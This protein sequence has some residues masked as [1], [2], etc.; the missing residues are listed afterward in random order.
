M[1]CR[2]RWVVLSALAITMACERGAPP[3][4]VQADAK[5]ANG[6]PRLERRTLVLDPED[7][8]DN[9]FM[10]FDVTE[11]GRVVYRVTESEGPMLRV[12]DSTG[13]RLA[14]FGR[15]GEGPGEIRLL[16][17]IELFG[18]TVQLYS[19][20]TAR[21]V[22]LDLAGQ[23][24]RERTAYIGDITLAWV[25]DSVDHW[26]PLPR[27]PDGMGPRRVVRS[28][29]GEREG[30]T[31]LT[32]A[33][34]IFAAAI[35]LR[36]TNPPLSFPY[37]ATPN[38]IWVAEPWDYRIR[39]YD[40]AGSPLDDVALALPPNRWGPVGAARMRDQLAKRP[41]FMRGPN[42]EAVRLPDATA[43]LDTL[44]RERIRHFGRNPL[45]LDGYGRLW[46]V[47]Y[48][49]DSTA[50]DVFEG[51]THLGRV[52]LPCYP[53]AVGTMVAFARSGWMAIECEVEEGDWPTELQLWR[54][55][56]RG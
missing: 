14:A 48:A 20:G 47:G 43:R 2:R 46:V 30:R 53:S 31:L 56:E 26:E 8:P 51:V 42:G 13:R 3:A 36:G 49:R 11:D 37:A 5:P 41:K 45:H 9:R 54:I 21:L 12:I 27:G 24:L 22:D 28:L 32:E 38:R 29:A 39:M 7:R 33:D 52:M 55:V 6:M 34:S 23:L 50:I 4:P 19:S 16:V 18:D 35:T 15:T 10:S 17:G 44:E 1:S 25:G 40:A